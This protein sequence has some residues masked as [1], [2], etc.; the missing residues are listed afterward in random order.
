MYDEQYAL[1][2]LLD[3][4][5]ENLRAALFGTVQVLYNAYPRQ[6]PLGKAMPNWPTCQQYT[7]HVFHLL[8]LYETETK[9]REVAD[10]TSLTLL[11]ELLC[12]CGAYLF[13]K[14]LFED[15]ER[16]TRASIEIAEKVLEAHDCLRAQ[17]YA[18]TGTISLR[19]ENRRD[20]A[21]KSLEL[22]LHIYEENIRVDCKD[23]EPPLHI[24]TQL[25][26]AY[27]NLGSAAKLMG[28]LGEAARLYQK[29]IEI[30]ER[31]RD[32]CA[33]FLPALS[34]HDVG[35]LHHL[36]RYIE[37]AAKFFSECNSEMSIYEDDQEMKAW[38]AV[39][40]YSLAKTEANISR[41]KDA[42]LHANESL[43]TL[44]S[45]M[46]EALETTACLRSDALKCEAKKPEEAT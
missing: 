29:A 12:D 14:C 38:Q 20:E 21:V 9:I 1:C 41:L 31:R 32:H 10:T 5:P 25:A 35:K 39:W 3:G 8:N 33:G 16:L 7:T 26:N 36:Q 6:C 45:V 23:T 2:E 15:S 44:K 34:L 30:E 28:D 40:L 27:N 19:S 37:E 18:L 13:A 17:P 11:T 22:A 42:E 43:Q 46:D 4:D 24:N